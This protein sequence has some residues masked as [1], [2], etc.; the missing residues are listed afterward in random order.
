MRGLVLK[1]QKTRAGEAKWMTMFMSAQDRGGEG[2]YAESLEI[3]G[4]LETLLNATSNEADAQFVAS[5]QIWTVARGNAVDQL[6]KLVQAFEQSDHPKAKEGVILLQAIIKN[7]TPRPATATQV[8]E[9]SRYLESDDI[10][11]EAE[12][13]NPFGFKVSI[14]SPLQNALAEVK[15]HVA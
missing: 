5:L 7:L 14:R 11:S 3:L 6:E 8:A 12:M 10:I 2:Q 4:R 9:L 13:P 1:A 15:K